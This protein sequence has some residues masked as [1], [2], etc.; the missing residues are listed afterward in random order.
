MP[1]S[2]FVLADIIIFFFRELRYPGTV[3]DR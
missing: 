1:I 2:Y 3:K